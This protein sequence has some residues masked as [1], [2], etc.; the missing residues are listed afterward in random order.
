MNGKMQVAVYYFPDYHVDPRNEAWH[1]PAWNEWSLVKAAT[2][3]F[4]GHRQPKVPLWGYLD[5]SKPETATR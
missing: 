5:E 4:P 3:R 1:G 2:P